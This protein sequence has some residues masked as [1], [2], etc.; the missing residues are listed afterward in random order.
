MGVLCLGKGADTGSTDQRELKMQRWVYYDYMGSFNPVCED[1]GE[2]TCVHPNWPMAPYSYGLI[3][4]IVADG[5]RFGGDI[6]RDVF[7]TGGILP[8][9][10]LREGPGEIVFLP[11]PSGLRHGDAMPPPYPDPYTVYRNASTDEPMTPICTDP[12]VMYIAH[13][14]YGLVGKMVEEEYEAYLA[15]KVVEEGRHDDLV[16]RW[17]EDIPTRQR[18]WRWLVDNRKKADCIPYD[19]MQRIVQERDEKEREAR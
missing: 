13:R 18:A 8:F 9:K 19:C 7:E 15:G 2:I 12:R 4:Y 10:A 17:C 3:D 16:R 5:V 11:F 6:K 14:G 1:A